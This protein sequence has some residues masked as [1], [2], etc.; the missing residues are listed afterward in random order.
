MAM[1]VR[2]A[3]DART[4]SIF[5]HKVADV[6]GGISVVASEL[7]GNYLAEGT[8]LACENGKW[9]A[10]KIARATEKTTSTTVK[11][12]KTHN[13]K[14]GDVVLASVGDKAST[15][16]K[17][18]TSAAGYDTLTLS[19][20]L[21]T[22]EAGAVLVEAAA[23][24][25]STGAALKRTPIALN[26]SGQEILP[27]SNVVTDAWVIGVIKDAGYPDDALPKGIVKLPY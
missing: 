18:D 11:V 6:R 5:V 8:P 15:I 13:F 22:I 24:Q 7:S 2:R 10:V 17:I 20:A 3:K 26:G 16:S 19:A 14:V 9:Y 27:N 1:T 25:T 12:E 23:A 4:K 21:G